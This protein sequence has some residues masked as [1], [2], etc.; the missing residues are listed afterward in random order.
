MVSKP[1]V[2]LHGQ[3]VKTEDDTTSQPTKTEAGK[4]RR[5]KERRQRLAEASHSVL[6]QTAQ[7]YALLRELRKDTDPTELQRELEGMLLKIAKAAPHIRR[8]KQPQCAAA[9][10]SEKTATTQKSGTHSAHFQE[11]KSGGAPS[12]LVHYPAVEFEPNG[13]VTEHTV[14][15]LRR[16]HP[17][18]ALY[19]PQIPPNTGTVS[20]LCAAMSCELHLIEPLGFAITDKAL[21]RAGL[22]YWE[23]L[24]VGLHP[25][26][27]SFH[28]VFSNRRFVMV[29][30]GEGES[31]EHFA[32]EPGDVLLFGSETK[33]LPKELMDNLIQNH[34]AK[35]VTIPMHHRGVRSLNLAN[36]VSIVL[37][38][39]LAKL[40][41]SFRVE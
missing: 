38:Q 12:P 15:L 5:K 33:G 9:L 26:F 41:E 27:D 3:K 29:E 21:R 4:R 32:F 1:K 30:T 37:Y 25:D 22:D 17:V 35:L 11:A 19:S 16:F 40:R 28:K 34:G 2:R 23:Q 36:T 20:R 7:L 14:E 10:Q 6:E 8:K 24:E 39:A 31:P 18:V 13:W